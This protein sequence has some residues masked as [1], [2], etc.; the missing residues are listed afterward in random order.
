MNLQFTKMQGTGNDYIY[1]D[2]RRTG[3]PA[4][5]PA[6]ARRLSQRRFSVGADGLICI[7]A[8]LLAD[9]DA[10]MYMYNADGSEGAMCGNGVRCVAEYLYTHGVRKDLI[11]LDT[12]RAGRKTLYRTGEHKWRAGMGRFSLRAQ[13]LP[14]V[15]LGAGPLLNV[16][17]VAG[18]RTW[19]VSCLSMG[20]PHCVVLCREEPPT[21]VPLARWGA[22]LAEHPAFPKGTNVEFVYQENAAAL[23]VTVWERGSG[24]TLSCGTGACA[25]AAVQVLQGTCPRNAE[26][27]VQLPGGIL[28][29]CVLEDDTVLLTGPAETV[30]AGSID[31]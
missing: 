20:N 31:L 14:V 13:D 12:P 17:L 2:C 10:T 27:Q 6:L 11:E 15:G 24:A 28:T 8:P 22:A 18:E 16:P 30:F 19:Q 29:V 4:D 5:A 1:L 9:A 26:I 21:G 7:G 3:L 25:A 23:M